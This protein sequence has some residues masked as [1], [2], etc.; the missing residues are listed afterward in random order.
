[1]N[2]L[3]LIF[4]ALVEF[5]ASRTRRYFL[6]T[7][8]GKQDIA[9][10]IET[11]RALL[12]AD[13]SAPITAHNGSIHDQTDYEMIGNV[14]S[15]WLAS[16]VYP[17]KT[18]LLR[19]SNLITRV[20]IPQLVG[21]FDARDP[22]FYPE[23]KVP[24]DTPVLTGKVLTPD[25]VSMVIDKYN[26]NQKQDN[27]L[28]LQAL[29]GRKGVEVYDFKAFVSKSDSSIHEGNVNGTLDK[30]V[31]VCLGISGPYPTSMIDE[32][33]VKAVESWLLSHRSTT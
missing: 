31:S 32:I 22:K 19:R 13:Y 26:E 12:N 20:Q 21:N 7:D 9:D 24:K 28:Q 6:D 8:Y 14:S 5:A 2:V 29:S 33:S 16:L 11:V 1:M 30:E 25:E 3:I 17:S 27:V 4:S 23:G 18:D 10:L 15:L